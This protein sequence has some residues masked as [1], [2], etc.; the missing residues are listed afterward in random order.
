MNSQRP[1]AAV[2]TYPGSNCDQDCVYALQVMGFE[3]RN[4]W[5]KESPDLKGLDLVVLPGG[6]S[7]G[8]YLRCGAMAAI[9]PIRQS[10]EAFAK[11]GGLVLGIC[12]GFQIL[13]E[14]QLL[15]GVLIRNKKMFFL[16]TDVSLRVE[17]NKTPWTSATK[18]AQVLNIPIAHGEGRYHCSDREYNILEKNGQILLRYCTPEGK[19]TE[20]SNLNGSIGSIAAVCNVE[21]NV[22]G[23]MPHPE[24]ATDLKTHDGKYFWQSILS[25]LERGTK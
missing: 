9:A 2:V 23:L 14:M 24:R 4:L 18:E 20:E 22:M 10:I 3:V 5:H 8:D 16:G 7:Y 19:L 12:N 17:N 6:F 25:K 13:C 15:P 21:G 1:Q 11:D